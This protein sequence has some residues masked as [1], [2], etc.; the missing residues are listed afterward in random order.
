LAD[1]CDQ[2]I[3]V[4][5]VT[6]V[7]KVERYQIG[8]DGDDF[9][10]K[11]IFIACNKVHPY[12]QI[13]KMSDNIAKFQAYNSKTC[14]IEGP[15]LKYYDYNRFSNIEKMSGGKIYRAK[16]RNDEQ[17]CV[18]KPFNLNSDI[19]EEIDHE[20]TYKNIIHA[21]YIIIFKS[22]FYRSRLNSNEITLLITLF[23]SMVSRNLSQ[24]YLIKTVL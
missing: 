4:T 14:L 8:I 2:I 18:L 21:L 5:R 3:H 17:Y 20:V 11:N 10:K 1:F 22:L 19:V 9:K 24:V 12:F 16:C 23:V 15:N 7:K 6:S 13:S